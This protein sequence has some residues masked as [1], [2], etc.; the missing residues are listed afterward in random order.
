[1]SINYKIFKFRN[2]LPSEVVSTHI[3]TLKEYNELRDIGLKL[4]QIIADEKSC[5]MKEIFN[6]MGY[7]MF[8]D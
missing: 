8:D 3:K 2:K 7:S 1:M 5:K 6:E 4:V